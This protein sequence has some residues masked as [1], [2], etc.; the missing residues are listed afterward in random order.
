MDVFGLYWSPSSEELYIKIVLEENTY[1]KLNFID[2]FSFNYQMKLYSLT[3]HI[4]SFK[5]DLMVNVY[6][7]A[8]LTCWN[9]RWGHFEHHTIP[10]IIFQSYCFDCTSFLYVMVFLIAQL[11]M[12]TKWQV[13]KESHF[14]EKFSNWL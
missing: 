2:F 8:S 11:A 12:N 14:L 4:L 7:R 5:V 6:H 10:N 13:A 3:N 1:L 9:Q